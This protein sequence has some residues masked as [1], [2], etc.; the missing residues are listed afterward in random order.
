MIPESDV[1]QCERADR[2][3]HGIDHSSELEAVSNLTPSIL[4]NSVQSTEPQSEKQVAQ[5]TPVEHDRL[6]R[7]LNPVG[8]RHTVCVSN[9]RKENQMLWTIAGI[10][11]LMW[12]LG[13]IGFHLAGGLIHIL[14]VIAVIVIVVQ[15]VTGRRA[16]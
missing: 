9:N 8:S 11:V 3:A 13:F 16:L 6:S 10:L 4:V 7:V 5:F 12:L 15:L 14:L 2:F 1:R